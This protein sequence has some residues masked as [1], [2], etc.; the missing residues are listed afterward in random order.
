MATQRSLRERAP[1]R[2]N[3]TSA[4]DNT[5]EVEVRRG[6]AELAARLGDRLPELVSA[7]SASLREDIAELRDEAQIP[8]LDAGIEGNVTTALYALGHDTPVECVR[9]PTAALE[10]ARRIAQ[11]GLPVNVLVRIYR[12]GQR[13]FTHLAF[14]ELQR[15]DVPPDA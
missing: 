10:Q 13:S 2:S 7:I 9:A 8:L 3:V 12:L 11:Q 4:A 14:G 5:G 6:I 15:I 1:A